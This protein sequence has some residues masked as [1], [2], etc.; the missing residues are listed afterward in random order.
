MSLHYLG[1]MFLVL[2]KLAFLN[3]KRSSK[4]Y[5]IY[6]ITVTMAFS[7]MFAFNLLSNSK[8]VLQLSYVMKSFQLVMYIVNIFMILVIC[9]LINYTTKFMFEKRSKEFGTYLILGIKKSYITKMFLLENII[10]GSFS[11]LLSL[12]I[13]YLFSIFASS[14]IMNIFDLGQLV[15]IDFSIQAILTLLLY[16]CIIYF[17]V[18]FLSRRRVKKIKVYD[19]FY[20]EK[21][22]EKR[23][24]KE[25]SYQGLFLLISLILGVTS[26]DLFDREFHTLGR[27]PSLIMIFICILFLLLSIYLL[28]ISISHFILQLVLKNKKIKYHSDNLFI[29]RCFASKMKTMGFTIGTLTAFIAFTL[30][31]LNLSSL[32]K[33]MF[34]YQLEV[35]APYDI[36]LDIKKE[37]IKKYE[38][39]I[40]E[41]YTIEEE[42]IYD[43]YYENNNNVMKAI[44]RKSGD[45]A[46][47]R[48]HDQFIKL[49]DYNKL[50]KLRG[51]KEVSLLEDEYLLHV[52]REYKTLKN[53]KDLK[54]I[55][56]S[57]GKQLKQKYF[58]TEGYTYAWGMG[59]GFTIVVPDSIVENLKIA[60]SHLIVDTK[61]ETTE[62]FYDKLAKFSD[63]DFC[64]YNENGQYLCYSIA[65]LIVRGKEKSQNNGFVTII[66]FVCFYIAFVFTAVVGTILAIQ[67][68][69]DSTKY[70]YRYQVLSKLG[71]RRDTLHKTIFK[72]LSIF[73]LFPLLYPTI[74]SICTL[75]SMNRIFKVSLEKDTVYLTYFGM[76][77]F[78]F[79]IIYFLYFLSTYFG[80]KKNVE[81]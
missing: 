25:A 41:H 34:D 40:K 36:S 39:F 58:F 2:S 42:L 66:A 19:L 74:I 73:F 71:V 43:S 32:F 78:L 31:A 75:T 48:E 15:K 13:G 46:G 3:A 9:F 35:V 12:P 52:T 22:N 1:E 59:Y 16:F 65:N 80:F 29:A 61:E 45:E 14:I 8:E 60:D 54:E 21:Q 7:L 24:K 81:E 23:R 70:K 64:Y 51:K 55:T 57:N 11:F 68:L 56:L 17:I 6:F 30:I 79:L 27:N 44:A 10:L 5:V 67:Q 38:E 63:D 76:N 50:L 62:A 4:D 53:D 37:D 28:S 26:L 77:I 69:S 33:G 49:S 47:W 18:L 20:L 72:Q